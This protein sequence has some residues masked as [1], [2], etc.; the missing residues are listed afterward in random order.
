M[1]VASIRDEL[2]LQLRRTS[3]YRENIAGAEISRTEKVAAP[4]RCRFGGDAH[5]ATLAA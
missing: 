2:F 5:H 3:E 1:R 4:Q